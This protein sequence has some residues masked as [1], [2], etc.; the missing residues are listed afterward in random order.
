MDPNDPLRKYIDIPGLTH[1]KRRK[2][3]KKG[4]MTYQ[5]N[6]GA[7]TL[8]E[9]Y[10]EALE[11]VQVKGKFIFREA[12]SAEKTAVGR[13]IMQAAEG[14]FSQA[15][16]M[17]LLLNDLADAHEISKRGSIEVKTKI[18]FPFNQ[19]YK[20]TAVRQ[21]ELNTS[22]GKIKLDVRVELDDIDYGQMHRAF[23]PN[24]IHNMDSMHK[25]MVANKL[26][27]DY[28]ITDFSM[29]HDSFGTNFADMALM[30]RVTKEVFLEMYE[31][32]N[33]MRFLYDNFKKQ[34]IGMKRF[35]RDEKGKKVKDGKGGFLTEDIPLS[36]VEDFG[37]FDFKDFEKLEYFF[38]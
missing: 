10:F 1:S 36:E 16:K 20:E 37:D 26:K 31:G 18:G 21:I 14:E 32:K 3:V 30:E 12:T 28:G 6:A 9:G 19:S 4:L 25:T 5:Y 34:G 15:S 23:A 8:G 24:I 33:F 17:R 38:H 13:I 27:N 29:I 11:G 22:F 2:S 35:I 7:R